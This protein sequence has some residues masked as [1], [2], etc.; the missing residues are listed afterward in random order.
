MK[1]R[2]DKLG[3]MTYKIPSPLGSAW[4]TITQNG[5]DPFEVFVTV[6]KSGSNT[7]AAAEG[8]GRLISL[9]FRMEDG[10]TNR[11]KAMEVIAQLKDIGSGGVA[12]VGNRQTYSLPDAIAQALARYLDIW[13]ETDG[14]IRITDAG[15]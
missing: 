6:G 4:V 13:E 10:L 5:E 1:P 14:P 3:G 8:F 15:G 2:P 12:G 7:H 11:E 9:I